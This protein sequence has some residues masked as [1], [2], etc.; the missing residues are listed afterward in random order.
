MK[1]LSKMQEL[2]SNFLLKRYHKNLEFIKQYHRNNNFN[3]DLQEKV[4]FNLFKNKENSQY[5]KLFQNN[6]IT[7]KKETK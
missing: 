5:A 6:Y 2:S 3:G 1:K 4:N 7:H